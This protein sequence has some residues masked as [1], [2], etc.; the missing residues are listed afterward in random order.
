MTVSITRCC[1]SVAESAAMS[2]AYWR[3]LLALALC[4]FVAVARAGSIEPLSG[5]LS[6]GEDANYQLTAEFGIDL[7]PHLE[8]VVSRG[9]PL[10]FNLDFELLR[11]RWYWLNERVAE[12]NIVHRLSYHA[13][14]RQ[15]RLS[16]GALHQNFATFAEALSVL[17]HVVVL[18]VVDK[19]VLKTGETYN[20]SLRLSLDRSQLPKPFQVESIAS[21][22]W[23]VDTKVLRWQFIPLD[24]N[25][26]GHEA[27]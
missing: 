2:A 13:L 17:S 25:N 4:A 16:S 11:P 19:S 15:Y 6:A 18:H 12:E 21:R 5:S 7:G 14:T 9:V 10:Y 22:D 23:Q 24:K 26:F 1:K 27:K 3:P 20:A 8:E